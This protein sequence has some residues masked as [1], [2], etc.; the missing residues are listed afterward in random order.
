MEKIVVIFALCA[1]ASGCATSQQQIDS[2]APAMNSWLGAPIEEFL[3]M[4]GISTAVVEKDNYQIYRFY[5]SKTKRVT[6]TSRNCQPTNFNEPIDDYGRP[7][8]CSTVERHWY[9]ATYACTYGLVVV[10]DVIIYWSMNGNNCRMIT[11]H[12]RPGQAETGL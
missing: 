12:G 11:V 9:T 4:Q 7:A 8:A 5:A 6:D 1:V 2:H 10:E 3:D